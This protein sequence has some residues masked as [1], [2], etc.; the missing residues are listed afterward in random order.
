MKYCSGESSAYATKNGTSNL[1]ERS[2]RNSSALRHR[3]A[4]HAAEPEIMK[5]NA[6]PHNPR[7]AIATEI[8]SLVCAF[9]TCQSPSS[10]GRR[11]W[12]TN[13]PNTAIT[14]NQS[15][16]HSRSPRPSTPMEQG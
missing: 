10:N 14:R 1:R 12:N 5:K 4:S 16:N 11:V 9:F 3:S 13:T 7:N 6:S 8:P 15:R 2:L